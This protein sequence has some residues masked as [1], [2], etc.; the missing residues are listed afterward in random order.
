[1]FKDPIVDE[2]RKIRE[3]QAQKYNFD[4]EEIFAQATKRQKESRQPTVS[5]AKDRKVDDSKTA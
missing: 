3:E 2:V 1:M 4:L 5:F